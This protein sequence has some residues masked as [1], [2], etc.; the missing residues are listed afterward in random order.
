MAEGQADL[1]EADMKQPN[2]Q[3]QNIYKEL[4]KKH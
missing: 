4:S 3:L 1:P 2:R